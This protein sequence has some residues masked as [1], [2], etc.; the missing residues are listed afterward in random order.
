MLLETNKL[1]LKERVTST[2]IVEV[3]RGTNKPYYITSKGLRPEGVYVRQG[4][5]SVPAGRTA[6]RKMIKAT[7][8]DSYEALRSLNQEL[9][10]E[11]AKRVFSEKG[12]EWGPAQL[13]FLGITDIDDLYT[14]YLN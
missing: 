2:I 7:D 9:T 3:Q 5:S 12:I 1:E 13:R 6:I 4:S 14:K 10:F 11:K 8:G